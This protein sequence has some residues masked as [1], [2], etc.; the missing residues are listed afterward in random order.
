M[1]RLWLAWHLAPGPEAE[2][3]FNG[4]LPAADD[5]RSL[6]FGRVFRSA[7]PASP[8]SL[9]P[10][11]KT[12]LSC[13]FVPLPPLLHTDPFGFHSAPYSFHSAAFLIFS[14]RFSFSHLASHS[15]LLIALFSL[16]C[17]L[18]Q[19][20]VLSVLLTTAQ[21]RVAACPSSAPA[22]CP[23]ASMLHAEGRVGV[24]DP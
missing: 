4:G 13:R 10:C 21:V 1:W 22:A 5:Q 7:A 23:A 8:A 17:F 14:N 9:V 16:F 20:I 15:L 19:A 2:H 11:L 12:P 6:F 3:P 24:S 18:A